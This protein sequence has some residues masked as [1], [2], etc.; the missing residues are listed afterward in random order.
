MEFNLGNLKPWVTKAKKQTNAVRREAALRLFR[1]VVFDTPVMEGTLRGNWQCSLMSPI[2][3]EV[4]KKSASQVM[5]DIE[6]VLSGSHLEDDIYLRNNLP[7]A[8]VV[9]YGLYPN[10]PKGGAGKTKG[11]FSIK[12]PAGMVRKNIMRL[13]RIVAAAVRSQRI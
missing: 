2:T 13:D 1:S 7:Y 12:A 8:V 3:G 6:L 4:E 10:P 11:G 9:E 5:A